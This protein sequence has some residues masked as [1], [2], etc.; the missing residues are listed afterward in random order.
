MI[1]SYKKYFIPFTIVLIIAF[2]IVFIIPFVMGIGLSFFSFRGTITNPKTFVGLNNYIEAFGDQ[3]FIDAFLFTLKFTLISIVTINGIAFLLALGLTRG[4]KG[5]NGIRTVIFM[6]NLIGGIVLGYI[7]QVIFNGIL[8][9]FGLG[10]SSDSVYGFWGLVI[11]VN[12]QMIGYMMIIYIAGI[13]NI[14]SD[15]I[16]A[17]KVDGASSFQRLRHIII[18]EL[19]P[20][21]TICLFLTLTNCFKLYD[22]N[23]AL[24]GGEPYDTTQMI[25]LNIVNTVYRQNAPGLG[26]AK[27]VIFFVL[28]GVVALIQVFLL[29][30]KEIEK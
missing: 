20:S 1:K 27:A 9:G 24:T 12:W 19:A 30:R 15:L 13:Q 16:E 2:I 23:L 7:W 17:S 18:P 5:S 26:Q 14:S 11:V 8:N 21:F 3:K 10:L 28:I 29:R 25:A 22:Q 6:P 4:H